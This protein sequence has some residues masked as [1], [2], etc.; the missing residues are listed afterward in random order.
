M[1]INTRG[2]TKQKWWDVVHAFEIVCEERGFGDYVKNNLAL[3][4][5]ADVREAIRKMR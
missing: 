5:E 2:F 3:A 1:E 4:T